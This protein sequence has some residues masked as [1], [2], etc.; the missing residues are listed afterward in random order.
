MNMSHEMMKFASSNKIRRA[1]LGACYTR[2]T[3]AP[4]M[5]CATFLIPKK[6]TA[7]ISLGDFP[8]AEGEGSPLVWGI[9]DVQA[10]VGGVGWAGERMKVE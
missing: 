1:E 6:S 10:S 4:A 8:R 9:S 2:P 5:N 3:D 7:R